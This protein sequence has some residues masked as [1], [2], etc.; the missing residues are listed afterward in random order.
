MEAIALLINSLLF[1]GMTLYSFGFAA[2]VF[3]TLPPD[4]SRK[5]IRLAFPHFYFFVFS[6]LLNSSP[7]PSLVDFLR[8][9][10]L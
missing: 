5:T 3:S 2:F 6:L 10:F 8:D 1:G 7:V 9:L 4:L